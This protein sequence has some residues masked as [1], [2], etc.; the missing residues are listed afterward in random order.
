MC[1]TFKDIRII[2]FD[3]SGNEVKTL[4]NE[5]RDPGFNSVQWNA[6]NNQGEPISAGVYLYSIEIDDLIQTRKMILLK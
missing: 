4:V 2:V 3:I 6:T 5:T 1:F